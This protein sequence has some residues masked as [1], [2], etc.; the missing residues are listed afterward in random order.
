MSQLLTGAGAK[1]LHAFF[2]S[3]ITGK[4][5]STPAQLGH[6]SSMGPGSTPSRVP[7]E[8]ADILVRLLPIISE[9]S[10]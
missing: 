8:V 6:H 10:W 2:T 3:V 4:Q 5:L 9:R 7:R 1:V